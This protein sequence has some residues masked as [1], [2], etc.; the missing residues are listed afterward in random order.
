MAH[1]HGGEH[2]GPVEGENKKI[3][4][5]ISILALFLA[6]SET[7]GKS[8]QTSALS[9]NIEASNLWAFYQ[10]KTIRKTTLETAADQ[11]EV[12]LKL[13]KDPAVQKL[14]GER[15]AKWR[16]NAARYESEPKSDG[17]GEG[18]KE[19]RERAMHAEASQHLAMEKYHKLELASAA[20]QIAIV[21]ASSYLITQAFFLLIGSLG[22]GVVGIA[23]TL[24]GIF[25]PAFTLFGGGH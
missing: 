19:L 6:I 14:L 1:G 22:L 21:L 11:M 24:L 13:A 23:F 16:D 18:R 7:V 5:L 17:R 3:A 2:H 20:F 12:D 25:A 15:I 9:F 4:I 8:A 10:A